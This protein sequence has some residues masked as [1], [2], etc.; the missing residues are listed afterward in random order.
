MTID[1]E[2]LEEDL[3]HAVRAGF[4][5]HPSLIFTAA[6]AHLDSLPRYK[7]VVRECHEVIDQAGGCHG[8]Y[9]SLAAA[10]GIA[11]LGPGRSVIRL[12]GTAKVKVTP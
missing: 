4:A 9:P 11:G 6:R 8:F 7:E 10:L 2:K 1:P 3:K 12:T 5:V